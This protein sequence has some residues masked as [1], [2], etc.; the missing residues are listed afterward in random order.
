MK[1]EACTTKKLFPE[2]K[3]PYDNLLQDTLYPWEALPKIKAWIKAIQES[4]SDDYNEV[5][6]G[7]FIHKTVKLY[8]NVYLGE[9]II[10]MEDRE[11]FYGKMFLREPVPYLETVVNLKMRYSFPMCKLHTITMLE[12]LF[13]GNTPTL[14]QEP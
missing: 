11:L 14:G 7:V 10:I 4:L 12:I 1:K 5:K 8:P 2:L 6:P 9:N 13:W 3:A